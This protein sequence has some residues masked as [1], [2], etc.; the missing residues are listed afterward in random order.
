MWGA[1]RILT[2]VEP[3]VFEQIGEPGLGWDLEVTR[4]VIA[5]PVASEQLVLPR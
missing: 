1:D 5:T 3:D 4:V 2:E